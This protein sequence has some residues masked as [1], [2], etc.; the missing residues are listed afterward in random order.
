[1]KPILVS[2]RGAV[3]LT[4]IGRNTLRLYTQKNVIRSTCCGRKLFIEVV[5]LERLLREGAPSRT[6]LEGK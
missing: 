1:M 3:A 5:E 2:L 6:A 4:G